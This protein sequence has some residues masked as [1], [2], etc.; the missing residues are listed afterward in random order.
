MTSAEKQTIMTGID[1]SPGIAIGE[2]YVLRSREV[3]IPRYEIEPDR[4]E[5]ELARFKGAVERSREQ[6]LR[7][8][9]QFSGPEGLSHI[10][11]AHLLILEDVMILEETGRNISE[12]RVNAEHALRMIVDRVMDVFKAI[13]D[14]YIRERRTDLQ[15][16]ADRVMRNLLGEK[17]ETIQRSL[18]EIIIVAHDLSP[19]DA[20]QLDRKLVMGFVTDAGGKT[21]HTAITARALEI[22]AVV[23][24]ENATSLIKPGDLLVVDGCT[25][26][27]RVNPDPAT[28]EQ[29]RQQRGEY[30]ALER[31]L[32]RYTDLPAETRD[33]YELRLVG[34]VELVEEIPSLLAHGGAGVGLFRTEF[35]YMNRTDLPDEE[36]HYR[37]YRSVVERVAPHPAVIRTLDLGGDKFAGPFNLSQESNP[38]LGLRAMRFC[39]RE[40]ELFKTQLAAI[41]R[42]SAHG[43]A[44][45]MFPLI[46]D[47]SEIREAKL[48]LAEVREELDA[49]SERYDPDLPVGIMVET[50]SSAMIS[51]LLAPEVDFFSIG[52]NDL[53]QYTLAVDRGNEQ[54]AYLYEPLHPAH[55]R[56]IQRV[57]EA[58]H[59]AG[60][61][62]MMCGEMA[63][64]PRNIL[65]LIGLSLDELSMN[66]LAIPCVKRIVRG[67]TL[68]EAREIVAQALTLPTA[69]EVKGFLQEETD[70]R[71]PGVLP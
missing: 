16:V 1:A 63:N 6:L 5:S 37:I 3:S 27:V 40:R 41:L 33:G 69:E 70:R 56:L 49:R 51:D 12:H 48:I 14:E 53:I 28:L 25:G 10:F 7:V 42:A 31:E 57:V 52:T 45:I 65:M 55:L 44:R 21:S 32:L 23:G 39:L 50:P 9:E 60:I 15:V 71:F 30:L 35:L 11:D 46:S 17:Q 29:C 4:I 22:P 2:A 67:T 26:V 66:S 59:A 61:P 54:V 58:G 64:D 36:E 20:A 13:D 43:R 8:K 68:R 24:L 38:A 47:V 19:A 62:V 34:N 18:T